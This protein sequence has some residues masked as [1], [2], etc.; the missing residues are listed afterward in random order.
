[1][2]NGDGHSTTLGTVTSGAVKILALS[3]PDLALN[4]VRMRCFIIPP[5]GECPDRLDSK[6][7]ER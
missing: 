4:E 7:T 1:M 3:K 2:S 6:I 5:A